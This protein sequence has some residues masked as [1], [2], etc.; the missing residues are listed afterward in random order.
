M[1]R[2]RF[3]WC[4]LVLGFLAP[5]WCVVRAQTEQ[6][7][8]GE[9][10]NVISETYACMAVDCRVLAAHLGGSWLGPAL[11]ASGPGGPRMG[12]GRG[13]LTGGPAPYYGAEF[14]QAGGAG[15]EFSPFRPEGLE[16]VVAIVEQNMLILHGT[17]EAIDQTLEILRMIDRP[18]PMVK[19][20]VSAISASRA[21]DSGWNL[22]WSAIGGGRGGAGG[23][24]G[25][26][27]GNQLR[28]AFGGVDLG[29]GRF[30]TENRGEREDSLS[31]MTE[32]GLPAYIGV[33]QTEPSFLPRQVRGRNGEII[34]VYD[35]LVTQSETSLFVVPR[36]NGDNSVT[37]YLSPQWSRKVGEVTAPGGSSF[38]VIETTGVD[39][40]VRARDGET[41]VIGGMRRVSI[42]D[43]FQN[44]G[45]IAG[46][47]IPAVRRS[48]H[49]EDV[50]ILVTP[51]VYRQEGNDP[52][53]DIKF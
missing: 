14:G 32:S 6:P 47:D 2:Y 7:P 18:A 38:P 33:V 43:T 48:V 41:I 46:G 50:T 22:Q 44:P 34:T 8:A 24:V 23:A 29:L 52:L 51:H 30:R 37:M 35:V 25:A 1:G 13:F 17:P 3:A 19:I 10:K 15:G 36:V 20:E 26:P 28:W 12:R 39:T 16:S 49:V 53:E 45:L 31:V 4:A 21:V 42:D 9:K 11:S 27:G 5:A 40:I